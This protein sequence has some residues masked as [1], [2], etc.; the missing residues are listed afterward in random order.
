MGKLPAVTEISR[1]WPG[2]TTLRQTVLENAQG[3]MNYQQCHYWVSSTEK[4]C[5]ERKNSYAVIKD[6][7]VPASLQ[8]AATSSNA[9]AAQSINQSVY[10]EM[11]AKWL[12]S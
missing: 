11:V 4:L 9:S 1:R 3:R 5:D 2:T 7:R 8:Y 12:N 6:G 10:S